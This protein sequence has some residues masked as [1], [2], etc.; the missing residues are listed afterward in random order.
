MSN[1][2]CKQLPWRC[3]CDDNTVRT[4]WASLTEPPWHLLSYCHIWICM[5]ARKPSHLA[6][7]ATYLLHEWTIQLYLCRE[8]AACT[9]LQ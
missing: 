4:M 9:I 2:S 7:R 6:T 8:A 5:H 3:S 1:Y